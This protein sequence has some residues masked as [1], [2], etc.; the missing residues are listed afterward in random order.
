MFSFYIKIDRCPAC[1]CFQP[2]TSVRRSFL[3]MT[4]SM[5]YGL[6]LMLLAMNVLF[7]ERMASKVML[8]GATQYCMHIVHATL[9]LLHT[10]QLRQSQLRQCIFGMHTST[11]SAFASSF[12]QQLGR[13]WLQD[14][15]PVGITC[16]TCSSAHT[17]QPICR[18]V[19]DLD[20]MLEACQA[21]AKLH[22]RL[23]E[24]AALLEKVTCSSSTE[25][26][27]V[28]CRKQHDAIAL[29]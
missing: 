13:C 3:F 21:C 29:C 28:R 15:S 12:R 1:H 6:T 26:S 9:F 14:D 16:T 17:C 8:V 20:D 27:A 23:A 24:S 25:K 7:W 19:P 22:E 4:S 11:V 18:H 5:V 2:A 10:G